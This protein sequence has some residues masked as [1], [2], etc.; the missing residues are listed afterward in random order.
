MSEHD[1]SHVPASPPLTGFADESTFLDCVHCGLCHSACPTYMELGTEADS[2]RGRIHLMQALQSGTLPLDAA[3]VRHLDLCLGC[4]ACETA[5]PSGVHYGALIEAARPWI[6][7][8]HRRP[9]ATRIRRR[10]ALA[11]L[12]HPRRLRIALAPLRL[13][14]RLGV[15]TRMRM[16]VGRL[17]ARWRYR[18]SLLPDALAAR[19]KVPRETPARAVEQARVQLLVGC[20]MPELF[21]DTVRSTL[22]VLTRNGCHVTA[23]GDQV[24]CG[25]L[26][27]HA[28]DRVNAE[29]CARAN[30]DAF[31]PATGESPRVV[32]NAAGCGA[33]MKEYGALLAGDPVYAERAARLAARV[34][35]ATELLV[36]L[37][38]APPAATG[39]SRRLAYH[40]PCHL[41]HAQGIRD[42]PR[43]LLASIPGVTLVPMADEDLCCGSAGHY[44]VMHPDMAARLVARK[45]EAMRASGADE[46]VTANAGCALQL[47]S[48]LRA[49][50]LSL[51]VRHVLDVLAEAYR[52]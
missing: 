12:P 11:L 21:G 22:D 29:R 1:A 15:L 52:R 40:D 9:L 28:G 14:E 30:V 39:P 45:V 41:A 43:T 46:I 3:A 7:A 47:E 32:V 35:D 44:N 34:V 49:A 5:C 50:G 19:A 31:E 23:P 25:A 26:A 18:A 38:M 33:M 37:P 13:L 27:L 10:V 42:A 4:R 17:P 6:E 48:G 2:P 20:V 16:F 36:R 8:R 51:R 24:C